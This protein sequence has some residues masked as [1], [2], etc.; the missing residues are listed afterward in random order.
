[1]LM[2][3]NNY[4]ENHRI[5]SMGITKWKEPTGE[6]DSFGAIPSNT[7]IKTSLIICPEDSPPCI[8]LVISTSNDTII[9]AAVIFAEGIFSGES[10][11]VHPNEQE[12]ESAV[13]VSL[14]PDKDL[15]VDLHFKTVVGYKG[16]YHY[17]V[18]DVTRKLPKFAM[19]ALIP[20]EVNTSPSGRVSFQISEEVS[21]ILQ[22]MSLNFLPEIDSVDHHSNDLSVNF[23]SIRDSSILCIKFN[24]STEEMIIQTDNIELAGEIIQSLVSDFLS[25]QDL[26]SVSSFPQVIQSLKELISRVEEIQ[27]VRQTLAA[28][29]ADTSSTVR[30]LII[31]SEDARLLKDFHSVKKMYTDL[32]GV[33]RELLNEY[34][35]REQNHSDLVSTLKQINL[36]IQ[37]AGNLRIGKYK[38]S[39]IQASRLAI[40]QNNLSSL[41]KII[42]STQVVLS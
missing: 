13:K 7:Q 8:Q 1:M 33:N 25:I 31:R 38:T 12:V 15:P 37:Q 5:Q 20:G 35:I 18:F 4:D 19:Y 27:S 17:H 30:S 41:S 32:A 42:S 28:D 9:R 23:L 36:L 22:W 6:E 16:S 39:L 21:K 24:Q 29:I 3:L 34:R 40:K 26:D 14:R 11:V 10:F 2:E